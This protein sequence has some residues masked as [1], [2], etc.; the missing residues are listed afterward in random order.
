MC[1]SQ[2]FVQEYLKKKKKEYLSFAWF[3]KNGSLNRQN[4]K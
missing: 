3:N 4:N 2:S 1:E